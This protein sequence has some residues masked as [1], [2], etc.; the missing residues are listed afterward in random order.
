MIRNLW[1][2]VR[3]VWRPVTGDEGDTWFMSWRKYRLDWNTAWKISF[4]LSKTK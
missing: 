1:L 2:F 3:I 4:N